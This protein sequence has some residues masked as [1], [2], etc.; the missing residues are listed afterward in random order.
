MKVFG[1]F[2]NPCIHESAYALISLHKTKEGAEKAMA[3]DIENAKKE[4]EEYVERQIESA[5]EYAKEENIPDEEREILLDGIRKYK[6]DDH[7][8]WCVDEL[9]VID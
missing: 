8:A 6:Y 5:L 7:V 2:H 9:E 1:F 4:H 3:E